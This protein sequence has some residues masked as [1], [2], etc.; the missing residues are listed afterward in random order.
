MTFWRHQTDKLSSCARRTAGG[1]C[2]H[3]RFPACNSHMQLR[4][5]TGRQLMQ[6]SL[7]LIEGR[8]LLDEVLFVVGHI[9]ES[10]NRIGCADGNTGATVDAS[11]GID[12]HLSRGFEPGLVLLGMDAVGGADFDA[13]GV[14]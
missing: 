1:G 8:I 2:P 3:M 4:G 6:M 13:E 12:V 11:L 7:M 5:R 10:V 9:V 14:L